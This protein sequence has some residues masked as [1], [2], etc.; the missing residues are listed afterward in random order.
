MQ[1]LP[2]P[3]VMQSD[4]SL[5]YRFLSTVYDIELLHTL[6]STGMQL[7]PA[8]SFSADAALPILHH[9]DNLFEEDRE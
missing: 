6:S 8:T 3:N 1:L 9:L 7:R 2:S 4:R 5:A